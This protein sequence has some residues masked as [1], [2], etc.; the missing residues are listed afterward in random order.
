MLSAT[1]VADFCLD[2][3][4]ISTFS[5]ELNRKFATRNFRLGKKTK[6]R[7]QKSTPQ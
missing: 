6:M 7:N 5:H 1:F 4:A 2:F 3:P